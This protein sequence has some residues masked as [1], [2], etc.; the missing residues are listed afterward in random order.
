LLFVLKRLGIFAATLLLA[1]IVVFTVLAVLPGDP[2]QVAAG[3]QATPEQIAALRSEYGLEG[4]V[5]QRYVHWLG[6]LVT[7]DL[8][9]TFV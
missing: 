5:P 2:A 4:S 9:T 6:D 3:T 8:G 7:G 1:S